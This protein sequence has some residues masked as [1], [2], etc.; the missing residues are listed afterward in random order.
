MSSWWDID[1]IVR[2]WPSVVR[3]FLASL[4]DEKTGF[5]G[6]R[7]ATNSPLFHHITITEQG[8]GWAKIRA[9]RNYYG[10]AAIEEMI[11]RFPRLEFSD[12]GLILLSQKVARFSVID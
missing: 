7:T 6:W 10:G 4:P 2:G 3:R 11:A 1:F 8:E 12:G 5:E 9:S